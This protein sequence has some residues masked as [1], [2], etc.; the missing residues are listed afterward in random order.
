MQGYTQPSGNFSTGN[1]NA[2]AV[3]IAPHL[4]G[5]KASRFVIWMEQGFYASAYNSRE[6]LAAS[7]AAR[8]RNGWH[9]EFSKWSA[10]FADGHARYGYFDTRLSIA[11]D[12]SWTIWQPN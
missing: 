8:Q 6:T 9:K 11:T 7:T 4:I 10:A 5:G 2:Y 1:V 12:A 3:R